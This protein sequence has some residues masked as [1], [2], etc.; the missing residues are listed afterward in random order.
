MTTINTNIANNLTDN[1]SF[2]LLRTN[3]K[4]TS[5]VKLIVDSVGSLF[6]SSFRANKELSRIEYQKREIKHDG[7]YSEDIASFYKGIPSAG[8]YQVMRTSSDVAMQSTYGLQYEDQYH[9][10]AIHNITKLY[11]EQYTIFAPIWLDKKIPSNFIVY[12]VEDVNYDTEH[13]EDAAGQ[14]SRVVELLKNATIV[15][16]FDLSIKS[17]IGKY[18][19]T[20]VNDKNFPNGAITVNFGEGSQS[21]YNGI[22]VLNGGFTSKAE[23]FDGYYTQVDYPEIFNNET[24]TDGFERNQMAIA[25]V[26]NLEF[27]FDDDN[28]EDYK[29]YRY[30]GLYTDSH[31]EGSFTGEGI[32]RHGV[33]NVK[34]DT[35]HTEYNV[36]S[37]GLSHMDMFPLANDF[38][39]PSVRWVKDKHG[40]FYNLKGA[41]N[42]PYNKLIISND[43]AKAI[44]F[45]GVAKNGK[46]IVSSNIIPN[47][48]GFIKIT[49]IDVPVNGDRLFITDKTELEISDYNIGD[50][51]ILS[52]STIPAGSAINN[53]FSNQGS[54][55]QIATAISLAIRNG[56]IITYKTYT[57]NTSV[58][59][60][61]YAAGNKRNQNAIGVY[62]SNVS[63]FLQIDSA[64]LNNIG[65]IDSIVP[66][67]ITTVFSDWEIYTM[68]GGAI[69][70]QS[71]LVNKKDIGNV[72]I[73][74]LFK[75]K[76][77][78]VFA[79]IIE[80]ERD[81]FNMET[82]R[83]ILNKP[84]KI[85]NSNMYEIYETY[86]IQ[87]G[88]FSVYGI[89]DFDFDFYSNRNSNQGD[90]LLDYTNGEVDSIELSSFYT[91]LDSV[92]GTEGINDND[93][94]PISNEYDRLNE[95]EL[96][97]T[98]I[99]SRIVPTICKFKL[100]D[101][102]NARN[103]P[104]ILNVN[105]AF[106]EDNLSPNI[107]V[108]SNRNTEHMN[109]EHFH[110]NKIPLNIL[111]GSERKYL[112]NYV[113]FVGDDHLTLSKLQNTSFN[114]F[115]QYFNWSGY[116]DEEDDIWYDNSNKKLWSKFSNSSTEVNSSTV[117]RGLRY[118]YIKRKETEREV[119]TEFLSD[120]NISDYSFGVAFTYNN[121][122]DSDGNNILSNDVS[123][124]SV[125]N[126]K[127]KF[128]CVMIELNIIDNSITDLDRYLMYTQNDITDQ[129]GDIIDTPIPFFIDFPNSSFDTTLADIE[130]TLIASQFS[131]DNGTAMF[132]K[133][134]TI[135][136]IDGYSWIKFMVGTT[137]YAV[138]V[139]GVVSDSIV[140]V[141]GWAYEWVA[142]GPTT[143]R[144][145]P[146]QHSL[147]N[148]N[149]QFTYHDGGK[150][151]FGKL[152]NSVNAYR[153]ATRFNTHDNVTYINVNVDSIITYNDYM[154]SIESG[155]NTIKPSLIMPY[156][157][158]DRPGAYQLSSHEIGS[159]IADRTDGGYI[160]VLRRMNGDYNPLFNDSVTFGDIYSENKV[161][162][163]GTLSSNEKVRQLVYNKFNN[164]P[165]TFD[166][167]KGNT[168]EYGYINNYFFH[169]VNEEDSKNVL[170][171]S[172]N[173]GKMPLYPKVHEVAI[174]MKHFN[175][176][177]SKYASDYF[178]KSISGGASIKVNGTL[179]PIEKKSFMSST[180]M[181]VKN[182]Y[183]ITKYTNTKE[184]SIESLDRIRLSRSSTHT[185]H[186]HEDDV[187]V[188][189]DVYM[190]DAILSELLEDGM[191]REFKKYVAVENSYDDKTTL[192]DD[193]KI[194]ND[195]NITPRFIIADTI[196]Y[197]IERK[198][199]STDF[200]SFDNNV[201]IESDNFKQLTDYN[202]QNYQNDGMSFRL[203]YN[204]RK[205]YSYN[206][207][208]YVKIQA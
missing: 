41:V 31:D 107:E 159:I 161:I 28:A 51:T 53:N 4:L 168:D 55:Q 146:S 135:D 152:L 79:S 162:K 191:L 72:K 134:I 171:L 123:I 71:I 56:E 190:S 183:N 105:E 153:M 130:A 50:Y 33:I 40:K 118:E 22:D 206:F 92:L 178:T 36:D 76:D 140:T 84:V 65:L 124:T 21:T 139:V 73:G 114:Y 116:Y 128:I 34:E 174:D 109:M 90:L 110:I 78:D 157:D 138:R 125:K 81:P 160:T 203:I 38:D 201:P 208:I 54:L 151:I 10:G 52:D 180:I 196:I 156:E 193:L 131:V 199:I 188:I 145:N 75:K 175:I 93:A 122:I 101:A 35:Y 88:R 85:S 44:D 97:E 82:Y 179:S 91:G 197:G 133:Y 47:Y 14:N 169:K 86:S 103:L 57:D 108:N 192:L 155:V 205:G 70:G 185:I 141:S 198:D 147:I 66:P 94:Q 58:I 150:N 15:K 148:I 74:E 104:Y 6:L 119:P 194:Y 99:L 142:G 20:H 23:Q 186:W 87:H 26:I 67:Q 158:P 117:F 25:N 3:P 163:Q 27:L 16:S 166:V 187:Q 83:I 62:N 32:N 89:K 5:N 13:T 7:V 77:S 8:K 115:E 69:E 102:S 182:E 17:K 126:D 200:V 167:H 37:V 164:L 12:R 18:L 207:K 9:Q 144:L 29:I 165:I 132:S 149:S 19:N 137:E 106:G 100:K 177:K 46:T 59:I 195:S 112:N 95:N 45:M 60:E 184:E 170:K 2:A 127:F 11:D 121:G 173:T 42:T 43:N 96:K 143:N 176:F 98:A 172:T 189:A 120:V 48:R 113:G 30:F 64:H 129:L 136:D 49:V 68:V 181:K 154:I 39:I 63:Q 204:K 202:I 80:I 24:L 61:D 111:G 1:R